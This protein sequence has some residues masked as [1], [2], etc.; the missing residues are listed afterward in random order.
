MHEQYRTLMLWLSGLLVLAG[1]VTVDPSLDYERTGAHI[2]RVT[3]QE[4]IY[5][6]GDDKVIAARPKRLPKPFLA[7]ALAV[8]VSGIEEVDPQIE[9]ATKQRR[10]IRLRIIPERTAAQPYL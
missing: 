4:E 9:R 7:A 3:G 8:E 1:C 10:V 6:P 2:S 5:R